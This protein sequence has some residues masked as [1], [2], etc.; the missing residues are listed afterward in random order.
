MKSVFG[1]QHLAEDAPDLLDSQ[2]FTADELLFI[3]GLGRC[4]D[5]DVGKL[6]RE[7]D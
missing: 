6:G 4:P 2:L 3:I 1:L 7:E 5:R